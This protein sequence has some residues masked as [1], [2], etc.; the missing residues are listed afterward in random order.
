[1][2]GQRR[3]RASADKTTTRKAAPVEVLRV[4]QLAWATALER[5]G[6]DVRRLEVLDANTVRIVN[7]H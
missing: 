1:M 2:A 4:N 7:T 6:G 3:T 5:A